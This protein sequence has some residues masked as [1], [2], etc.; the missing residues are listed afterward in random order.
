MPGKVGLIRRA[1]A[2]LIFVAL[3][4][5]L[6]L[7]FP[8]AL[9][10][11]SPLDSLRALWD[12]GG[13]AAFW[14]RILLSSTRIGLG[15]LLSASA[16]SAAAVL[17]FHIPAVEVFFAPFI[18]LMKSVPLAVIV[19]LLLIL[20]SS[21]GIALAVVSLVTFPIFY[22]ALL[23]GARAADAK[24]LEMARV[25]CWSE[26]RKWRWIRLSAARGHLRS[27]LR[28]AAGMAWK[29]GVSAEVLGTP[30]GSIGEALYGAKV[31]LDT[32]ELFA[33]AAVILF[34][35]WLMERLSLTLLDGLYCL[36]EI[37]V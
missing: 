35:G 22:T 15:F 4:Q 26:A 21:T 34:L 30:Q 3:W 13:T 1:G 23:A 29:A 12:L 25:F 37:D 10:V 11:A 16:A 28:V 33:W 19:I 6:A 27:A 20:F 36:R 17:S 8:G 7:C 18:T 24:L 32:E 2:L 31:Y 5:L 9:A 14:K